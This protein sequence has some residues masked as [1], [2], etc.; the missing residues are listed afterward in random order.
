MTTALKLIRPE[1]RTIL[2]HLAE[3]KTS[4]EIAKKLGVSHTRV[5]QLKT[6]GLNALRDPIRFQPG[7]EDPGQTVVDAARELSKFT[8]E[9]K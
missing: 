5:W 7:R 3:G 2:A 9:D 8:E 6:S 4:I 1:E